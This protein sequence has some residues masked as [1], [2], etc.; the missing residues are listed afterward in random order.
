MDRISDKRAE[1]PEMT[2][3]EY[4]G[5][6]KGL[7]I[8]IAEDLP[9]DDVGWAIHLIDHGEPAEGIAALAWS[10][11]H[12]HGSIDADMAGRL[13]ELIGDMVPTDSLPASM[14]AASRTSIDGVTP[15]DSEE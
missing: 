14:Q 7:V 12:A 6:C 11:E 5:R 1:E 2:P 15:C 4:V 3:D 13:S 10:L 9:A 8:S